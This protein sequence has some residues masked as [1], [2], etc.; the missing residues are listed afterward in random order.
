MK[1]NLLLKYVLTPLLLGFLLYQFRPFGNGAIDFLKIKNEILIAWGSKLP[2]F[3]IYNLPDGLWAFALTSLILIIWK[4]QQGFN[5]IIWLIFVLIFIIGQE[6]L[7]KM[8]LLPGT[9]DFLDVWTMIGGYFLS[10]LILKKYEGLN[11]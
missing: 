6:V 9:F 11:T 7:Q 1:K 2:D 10:L 8:N 5:R 4:N 3:C